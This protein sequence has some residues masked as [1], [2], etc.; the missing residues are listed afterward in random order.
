MQ[1]ALAFVHGVA[2]ISKRRERR[3]KVAYF[4]SPFSLR[5]LR[6]PRFQITLSPQTNAQRSIPIL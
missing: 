4:S 1:N 5:S 6:P 2:F 3:E